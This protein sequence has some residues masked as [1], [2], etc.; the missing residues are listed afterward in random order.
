MI[1]TR[2]ENNVILKTQFCKYLVVDFHRMTLKK[3]HFCQATIIFQHC[4]E[5]HQPPQVA[6]RM[7]EWWM[8]ETLLSSNLSFDDVPQLLQWDGDMLCRTI[9]INLTASL[10]RH[11]SCWR[12]FW[13]HYCVGILSCGLVSEQRGGDHPLLQYADIPGS[14]NESQLHSHHHAS[15]SA[16]LTCI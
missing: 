9:S 4:L 13:G 14:L 3:I 8:L 15:L 10:A 6:I 2:T 11:W 5:V 7:E 12:C 1:L 16:T